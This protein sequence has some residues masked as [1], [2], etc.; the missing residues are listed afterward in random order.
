MVVMFGATG[1]EGG[2]RKL[3]DVWASNQPGMEA[4][5]E[6]GHVGKAESSGDSWLSTDS[7]MWVGMPFRHEIRA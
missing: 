3:C 7:S 2:K 4:G 6:A 5:Q 1:Q